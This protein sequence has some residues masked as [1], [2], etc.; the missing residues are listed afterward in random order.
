MAPLLFW[1]RAEM[2]QETVRRTSR[3][4]WAAAES[5]FLIFDSSSAEKRIKQVRILKTLSKNRKFVAENLV[6]CL[7]ERSF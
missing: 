4:S 1:A 2:A 3:N 7:S 6:C 5:G